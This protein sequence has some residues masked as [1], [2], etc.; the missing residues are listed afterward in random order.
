MDYYKGQRELLSAVWQMSG[1]PRGVIHG[2]PFLDNILLAPEG[3]GR[4]RARFVDFED[5]CLGPL[6]FDVACACVASCFLPQNTLDTRRL[7]YILEAY[8]QTRV[9][10]LSPSEEAA[11]I[12][13]MRLALLCNASW[14]FRKFNIDHVDADAAA[15]DSFL[16]LYERARYLE[17]QQ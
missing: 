17:G 1:L 11:L 5:G 14:R 8:R 13:F 4:L 6:I 9:D 12:P 16:E 3:T 7:G 15:R 10:A 2:D